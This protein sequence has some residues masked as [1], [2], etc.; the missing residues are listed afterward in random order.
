MKKRLKIMIAA[1]SAFLLLSGSALAVTAGPRIFINKAEFA[2][3]YLRLKIEN[4]TAMVS[5]RAIVEQL[6]GEV[7]YKDNSI[8]VSLP[9][10]SH[11]AHQVD[12]FMNALQAETPEEAA[13]TWIRGI[14][15]RSGPMQYAVM[16]PAL[17]KSTKQEFEDNFWVT[18]VSSPHMGTVKKMDTKPLSPD[19]VQITFDYPLIASGGVI[20]SGKASLTIEKGSGPAN[21]NWAISEIALQD[22]GDTGLMIGAKKIGP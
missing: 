10:A 11:L 4:G 13:K 18:G 7:T 9:E 17:Q 6:K 12:G 5:L 22:P 19:K 8:H 14:Q 1:C 20:G 15:K 21:D 2:S 3:S 16:T